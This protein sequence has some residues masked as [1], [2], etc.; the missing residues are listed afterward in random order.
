MMGDTIF[1][2][3]LCREHGRFGWKSRGNFLEQRL[4]LRGDSLRFGLQRCG[5]WVNPDLVAGMAAHTPTPGDVVSELRHN[6][7]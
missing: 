6:M 3:K 4:L 2:Q 7:D 5:V 1:R